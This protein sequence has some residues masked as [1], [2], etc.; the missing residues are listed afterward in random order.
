MGL[1]TLLKQ[2][3]PAFM[4]SATFQKILTPFL[5]FDTSQALILEYIIAGTLKLLL[6]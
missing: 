6:E 2:S 4:G 5:H 3:K 1:E